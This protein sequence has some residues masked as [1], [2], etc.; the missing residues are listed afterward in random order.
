MKDSM[1]ILNVCMDFT[2]V[3]LTCAAHSICFTIY[4][5]GWGRN[6][7]LFLLCSPAVVSGGSRFSLL[8]SFHKCYRGCCAKE[9][10]SSLN[11]WDYKHLSQLLWKHSILVSFI[12]L[13]M[14]HFTKVLHQDTS[15][16]AAIIC[17]CTVSSNC[18]YF[19]HYSCSPRWW[20]ASDPHDH[21]Y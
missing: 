18:P 3:L 6:L 8:N 21:R 1:F 16:K 2:D 13:I 7:H 15:I 4:F 17:K 19:L 20:L 9:A 11:V 5:G 10:L 12:R 14:F